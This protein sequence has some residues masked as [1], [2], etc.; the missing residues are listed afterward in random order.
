MVKSC[1]DIETAVGMLLGIGMSAKSEFSLLNIF[2][3]R[4]PQDEVPCMERW[5]AQSHRLQL[6]H[7]DAPKV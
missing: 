7:T 5:M 2:L 4:N 3:V 6:N 1:A